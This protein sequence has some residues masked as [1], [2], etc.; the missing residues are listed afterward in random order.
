MENQNS[1]ETSAEPTS[2]PTAEPAENIG[3]ENFGALLTAFEQSHRTGGGAKQLEGTVVSLDAE[4]VFLDIGFKVEGILPRTA[5]RDNAEGV[6]PGDTF[7]VSVKGRN[8]E[9]YYVLSL[10]RV[11]QPKDWASLEEAFAQKSAIV[12]TVTAVVKGGL[13]VDV[14]VRAFLP[15]SRSGTRDAAEMEKL[16]G[17]EITCRIIK[18]DVAD[19][20]VVVDRR[21]IV[22]EE[23]F[24]QQQ[25][26]MSAMKEGDVVSGTVRSLMSY[27]AF[28]DIGGI[29]GLL[30]VSDMAWT[31]VGTPE[32]VLTVGE[33]VRV[34]VLKIDAENRRISLG[35]KQLQPEPWDAAGDKYK[36][37]QR[38]TATVTRLTDFGAFVEL[39]PGIEGLIHVSEMSWVKKVRRPS[40]LLKQGDTVEAVILSVNSA[41][42]RM[43]LGLKQALGDPWADVA[44]KYPVGSAVEGPVTRMMKFGAFVQ[45]AEGVEGLVH[46][47]EIT[48][49]RHLHHPQEVLKA[50]QVVRA[51]VL[52]IDTEKRQMKLSMKQLVPT[53]LNEY[54]AEHKAGDV[55]SG[56][57][58]EQSAGTA[59]VELGEGIRAT[60]AAGAGGAEAGAESAG[61]GKAD[62]SSLSSMLQARWKGTATAAAP[63]EPV[64]VGQVR[65]FR[66]V[67]MDRE[68]ERIGLELA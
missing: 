53:S 45:V 29:D 28:V 43:S 34:K 55:V 59:V 33:A 68:A 37:G 6:K 23:A 31:R 18:L 64:R 65:S 62:L 46:I 39:E 35:L 30:H 50:G 20:D 36:A 58:I 56:R 60:C 66:I 25:S 57:V 67:Q 7:P 38:V 3:A 2:Q 63:P 9:R 51:Q 12:G 17:Q 32:D 16:V 49:E 14:G 54:L 10:T 5:F 19:E 22:E 52:A 8:E 40:D 15:A 13:S 26:Q 4:S 11:S 48:A 47:S 24:A 61:G 44:K 41:E 21:A 27:G 1:P 42:K